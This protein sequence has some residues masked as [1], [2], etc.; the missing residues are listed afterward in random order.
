MKTY[1]CNKDYPVKFQVHIF[2]QHK[3]ILGLVTDTLQPVVFAIICEKQHLIFTFFS[4]TSTVFN[5]F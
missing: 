1:V 5:T 2:T 3:E 4:I